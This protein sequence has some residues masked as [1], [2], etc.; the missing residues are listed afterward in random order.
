MTHSMWDSVIGQDD[1]VQSLKNAIATDHLSHAYL[2]VGPQ[3]LGKINA[4]RA[5]A[6]GVLCEKGG[7]G[8]CNVCQRLKRDTHPDFRIIEPEGSTYLVDQI[9]TLIH[10]A[11]L[12]PM[13]ATHKFYIVKDA[14]LFNDS[15]ANAFLKT[16]EEPPA[17]ITV[18]LLAHSPEPILPTILSRCIVMRF[19][20]LPQE[21]MVARLIEKTGCDRNEALIA[22]A[23]CSSVISEAAQFLQSP[24]RRASRAAVV[25]VFRDLVDADDLDVLKM[26][27]ELMRNVKGPVEE[28]AQKQ[29]IDLAA[30][31]ELL[32]S[33]AIA[34]L[35]K[36]NDRKRSAYEKQNVNE[37]LST[38]QSLLRDTLCISQGTNELVLNVDITD[39]ISGIC[40]T[41]RPVQIAQVFEQ[42]AHARK[43]V[44]LNISTQLVIETV[45][46]EI[47]EVLQC[48]K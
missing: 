35:K 38:L 3:G 44:Q 46:F 43:R 6:A 45:L 8:T 17:H 40:H 36:Y 47:R 29:E 13:E 26:A 31:A 19:K 27:Q 4:A 28:M 9:R 18:I 42:I 39:D 11:T 10:D 16:L 30:Q 7:C 5:L 33:S 15:S 37:V 34:K 20:T 1:I 25:R 12:A 32:D 21:E 2:F 24:A 23:S 48:P 22:L 14:D 41:F